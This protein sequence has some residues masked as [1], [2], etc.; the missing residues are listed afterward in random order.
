MA[1]DLRYVE[2]ILVMG[3]Y[4][5]K[6]KLVEKYGSLEKI[7]EFVDTIPVAGLSDRDRK[8]M[9]TYAKGGTT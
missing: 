3:G 6:D 1:E 7:A 8:I 2:R 4:R 9:I 5:E